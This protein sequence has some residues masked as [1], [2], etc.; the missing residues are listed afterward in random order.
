MKDPNTGIII[1]W[2][3]TSKENITGFYYPINFP[4]AFS[5]AVYSI[6]TSS[7]AHDTRGHAMFIGIAYDVTTRGF[8]YYVRNLV[9]KLEKYMDGYYWMAI[10][11]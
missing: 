10:G 8:N 5:S 2:G 6:T 4:T 7:K 11:V 9:D 1:Q 3:Y